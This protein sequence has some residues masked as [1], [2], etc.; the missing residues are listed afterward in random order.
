MSLV[1]MADNKVVVEQRKSKQVALD[2]KLH[3]P[4]DQ[5]QGVPANVINQLTVFIP[6]EIITLWVALI[7]LLNYPKAPLHQS[8]CQADFS[9]WWVA[10]AIFAA[11]ASLI[12]LGLTYRKFKDAGHGFKWPLFEMVAAPTAF[13]A[14]AVALPKSPLASACWYKIDVGAF[15]VLA[16]T[17]AITTAGYIFGKTA[18]YEKA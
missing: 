10:T 13:M 14:W 9:G 12:T 6:T 3:R 4:D 7:A 15:I 8:L 16:T 2:A 17:V 11:L 1:G 5:P 18:R